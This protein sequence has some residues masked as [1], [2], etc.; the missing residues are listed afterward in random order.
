MMAASGCPA[1]LFA[2]CSTMS[3]QTQRNISRLTDARQR[4]VRNNL[5][6]SKKQVNLEEVWQWHVRGHMI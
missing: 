5:G 6:R 1:D 3:L 4:P 2:C